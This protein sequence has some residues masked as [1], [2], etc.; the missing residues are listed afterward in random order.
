MTQQL[1]SLTELARLG[2]LPQAMASLADEVKTEHLLA[3]SGVALSYI[4]K[5]HALPLVSWGHDLIEA[6]VAIAAWTLLCQRGFNPTNPADMS[7]RE[8]YLQA[9]AWLRDVAKGLAELVDVVDA[10]PSIQ[11]AGPLVSSEKR[12]QWLWGARPLGDEED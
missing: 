11:E 6:V 10:T 1:A 5:R 3:A 7:V 12:H 4:A 2:H 8:R 9:L